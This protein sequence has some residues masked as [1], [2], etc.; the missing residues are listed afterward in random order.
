MN[1]LFHS[2]LE[3][4]ELLH[5]LTTDDPAPLWQAADEARAHYAGDAVHLRA[6]IEIGNCCVRQCAY[7]GLRAGNRHLLRYRM[8][9]DEI[10]QC[11]RQAAIYGFG[12][13]VLQSGEDPA[14]SSEDIAALIRQIK[15]ETALAV[16]L[17]LGEREEEELAQW[18]EAGADRYLLRFETSDPILFDSIHPSLPHR[19]SDRIALLHFLRSIGYEIGSGMMVGIP[20]QTWE[21]L[22]RDIELLRELDL[23]MIGIGPFI[24]NPHTP[25]GQ[26]NGDPLPHQIPPTEEMTYRVL[27]LAR[28]ACPRAN[29]PSTTALATLNPVNGHELAFQRGANVV[30]PNITPEKYR[31]RYQLYPGKT[32]VDATSD[33]GRL[34]IQR[35][36]LS[37]GRKIG[38][39]AGC[40]PRYQQCSTSNALCCAASI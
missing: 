7:C 12:T 36:I 34:S 6:L 15:S 35:R 39:G 32:S 19:Q 1:A 2:R 21:S 14:V 11:A 38:Q 4:A 10:T 24:P 18:K 33:E 20:G 13:V 3:R 37:L 17:S 27:A 29:I 30:M 8:S 22:A 5:W 26:R 25:L 9:M 28:L 16:T 40:S 31:A 23:D